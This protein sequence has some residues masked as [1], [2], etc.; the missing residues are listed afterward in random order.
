FMTAAR[1]PV[2]RVRTEDGYQIKATEWHDFY[3]EGRGKIKLR[4]L[5]TGDRLLVQS[6][7]GQFGT[8]GS[9]DLGLLIGLLTG[10]GHFTNRGK[11]QEAAVITLWGE[12][13]ALAGRMAAYVNTL[14]SGA[15]LHAS[16]RK[17][18]VSP[19]AVQERGQVFIRSVMLA[20]LLEHYGF[21]RRSKLKVPEVVWRGSEECVRAYLR[22]LFQTDGTVNVSSRRQ[23][24]SIR[25]ASSR[26]GLL[27][28]NFV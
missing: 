24:C 1:A 8:Q 21:T 17:Y 5:R 19:V 22:G 7:K 18:A 10:D 11:G 25:L 13:R 4:E 15:S 20:R 14:I 6:G 2:Y 26:E 3:V 12:E 16:R 9:E 27:R 28:N 23:S